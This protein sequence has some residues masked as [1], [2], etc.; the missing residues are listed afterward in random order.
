M[1]ALCEIIETV[2]YTSTLRDEIP[3]SVIFVGPSGSGKSKLIQ[4]Y[5]NGIPS[6]HVTDSLTSQGI[7]NMLQADSKNQKKFIL[8][9]DINPTLARRSSTSSA[10]VANLL[11]LTADGTVRIDDG[12]EQKICK[13]APVGLITACTSEV[14]D[15]NARHWFSLGLRRRVLPIFYTYTAETQSKLNK[16]VRSNKIT[17]AIPLPFH[18]KLPDKLT[19]PAIPDPIATEIE[20]KSLTFAKFL[21]KLSFVAEKQKRWQVRDVLPISPHVVLRSLCMARARAKNRAKVIDDDLSFIDRFVAFTDP[22]NPRQ[23]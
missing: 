16:L 17:S 10:T 18:L 8:I 4:R 9:P 21:G 3:V 12:R 13:H 23:I 11:S 14:Y 7:W 2:L 19:R 1:E 6:I 22:E 20:V 5:D 15:K